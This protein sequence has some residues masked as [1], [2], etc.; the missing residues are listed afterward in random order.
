VSFTVTPNPMGIGPKSGAIRVNNQTFTVNE[1]AGVPC[2]YVLS[3]GSQTFSSGAGSGSFSVSTVLTC[4]WSAV[5]NASWITITGPPGGAGNGAV[6]FTIT[7]NP[8]GSPSR[9][10]SI[11]VRGQTFTIVQGAGGSDH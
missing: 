10:G 3:S 5:S 9:T 8:P 4:P 2:V 7:E 11:D 6:S 1:A